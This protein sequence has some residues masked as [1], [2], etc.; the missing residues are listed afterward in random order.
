MHRLAATLLHCIIIP[1]QPS[2]YSRQANQPT[3]LTT[4][5]RHAA[6]F[7]WANQI[8]QTHCTAYHTLYTRCRVQHAH[9][10]YR[11]KIEQQTQHATYRTTRAA[12][13]TTHTPVLATPW[14]H[15]ILNPH[16]HRIGDFP[17]K[18]SMHFMCTLRGV[19]FESTACQA[20]TPTVLA[21]LP[22]SKSIKLWLTSSS[23][24][25][26]ASKSCFGGRREASESC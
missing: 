22:E 7:T 18:H 26:R 2:A 20:R 6:Y 14:E 5:G 16:I 23:P 4:Q 12:E 15:I 25:V 1:P 21:F 19:P 3:M 24:P 9:P 11:V 13:E 10:A 8:L 17:R